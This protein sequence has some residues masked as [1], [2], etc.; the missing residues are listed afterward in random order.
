MSSYLPF[1]NLAYCPKQIIEFVQRPDMSLLDLHKMVESL[2]L[3][4][5]HSKILRKMQILVQ[6][7]ETFLNEENSNIRTYVDE[8]SISPMM[9]FGKLGY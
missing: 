1:H 9:I 6:K 3:P 7:Q 2:K 8:D 5:N 4:R